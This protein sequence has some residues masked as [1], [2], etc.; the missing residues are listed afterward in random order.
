MM[1]VGRSLQPNINPAN[2]PAKLWR[3]V[4]NPEVKSICWNNRGDGIIV[5]QWLMEREV[6]SPASTLSNTDTFKTT[7][8]SSFVR[9][10]NLYGFRKAETVNRENPDIHHFCHPH[11]KQNHPELL[12][13]MRRLIM[14]DK[15][16]RYNQFVDE[17]PNAAGNVALYAG[18]HFR[19][20]N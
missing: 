20:G 19:V 17:Q 16:R 14:M 7:N 13:S 6:L 9:Q 11:F 3:L 1:D 18:K 10:L 12:S 8:Y 2:F 4:N 15:P 5:N